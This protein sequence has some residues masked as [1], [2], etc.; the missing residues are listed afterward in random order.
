MYSNFTVILDACVL[1]PAPIRDLLLQLASRGLFRARWTKKI[2]EEWVSS[3]LKN[4][5][6]ITREQLEWTCNRMRTSI[7]D[8]LVEDYEDLSEGIKLLILKMCMY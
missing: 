4:R 3:L 8:C 5:P 6:D 7:R 1:Y 2:E